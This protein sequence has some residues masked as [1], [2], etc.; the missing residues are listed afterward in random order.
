MDGLFFDSP[1][2]FSDRDVTRNLCVRVSRSKRPNCLRTVQFLDA[3][4]QQQLL[5]AKPQ[6]RSCSMTSLNCSCSMTSFNRACEGSYYAKL[7]T[8]KYVGYIGY[9]LIYIL[10]VLDCKYTFILAFVCTSLCLGSMIALHLQYIW[11]W[12]LLQL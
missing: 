11:F 3:K 10:C 5:D 1:C 12:A 9:D 8:P 4:L 2:M 7:E 6:Q